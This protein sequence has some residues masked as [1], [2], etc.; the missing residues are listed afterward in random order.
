MTE[1]L[2]CHLAGD[3]YEAC[4]AG[5]QSTRVNLPAIKA[6]AEKGIDISTHT[7]DHMICIWEWN[8]IT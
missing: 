1:G 8:L 5:M 6:M 7:S 4:S 2:L 3:R